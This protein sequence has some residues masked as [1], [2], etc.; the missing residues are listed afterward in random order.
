[1]QENQE[2]VCV[3]KTR[4]SASSL[5]FFLVLRHSHVTVV[6]WARVLLGH[7]GRRR[8]SRVHND[9]VSSGATVAPTLPTRALPPR[10][11]SARSCCCTQVRARPWAILGSL[12]PHPGACAARF[13]SERTFQASLACLHRHYCLQSHRWTQGLRR[14]PGM[15]CAI[16]QQLR[17]SSFAGGCWREVVVAFLV[18]A[19]SS[20][21]LGIRL[22]VARKMTGAVL[23]RPR[24]SGSTGGFQ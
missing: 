16:L 18:A 3:S 15:S 1:M 11:V 12:S 9:V 19:V 24:F 22:A 23:R 5:G 13:A 17:I 6:S 7:P 21:A 4:R 10:G 2:S 8:P 14:P 20:F